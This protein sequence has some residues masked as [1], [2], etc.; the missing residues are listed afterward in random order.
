[1]AAGNRYNVFTRV[2]ERVPDGARVAAKAGP[3]GARVWVKIGHLR[4][5]TIPE[6]AANAGQG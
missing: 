6:Q 1:M 4:T 5:I 2:I 3:E